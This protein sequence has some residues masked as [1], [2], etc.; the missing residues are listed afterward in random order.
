MAV[1]MQLCGDALGNATPWDGQFLVSFD[2][3]ADGGLGEGTFSP[4]I[5]KA[6]RF[7]GMA[8]IGAFYRTVPACA[9]LR[10]DGRP[11]RPL[12]ATNWKI[13]DPEQEENPQ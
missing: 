10:V 11:N 13:F 1:V 7:D 2:F 12:T 6:R 3:E 8:E 5:A 4:D 9:P